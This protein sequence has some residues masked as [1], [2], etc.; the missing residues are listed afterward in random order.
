MTIQKLQGGLIAIIV[1]AILGFSMPAQAEEESAMARGGQLY[2]K[3]YKLIDVD[4]PKKSHPAYPSDKKYAKKPEANWRC[5]ECHG[6]D[7]KGAAGVYGSGSHYT[8]FGG[9]LNTEKTEPEIVII[10]VNSCT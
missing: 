2:D 7:Y 6:W 10:V 8:G 9:L 3:W 1:T 4:A 5:K